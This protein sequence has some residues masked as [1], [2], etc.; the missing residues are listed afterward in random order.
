MVT[1]WKKG[2][3]NIIEEN[4]ENIKRIER[5]ESETVNKIVD[6]EI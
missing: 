3:K 6:R 5:I 4:F 1:A 2:V